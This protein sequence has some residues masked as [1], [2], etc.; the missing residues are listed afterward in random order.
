MQT[1]CKPPRRVY[2]TKAIEACHSD[3]EDGIDIHDVQHGMTVAAIGAV[4]IANPLLGATV[5]V[6]IWATESEEKITH[7]L[8]EWGNDIADAADAVADA[9]TPDSSGPATA[10]SKPPTGSGY[11]GTNDPYADD[12]QN[13]QSG[14]N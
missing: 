12:H 5:A 2:D 14:S 13:A 3:L 9:F 8:A 11:P 6:A 10:G 1:L 4:T 7:T